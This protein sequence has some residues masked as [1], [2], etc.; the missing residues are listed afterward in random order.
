MVNA[1]VQADRTGDSIKAI[2]Q[3]VREF[4]TTKGVTPAELTREVNGT[5]RELAGRFETS[6]AVLNAMLQN[7]VWHRPDDFYDTVAQKY[8]AMT[9]SQLD[10]AMRGTL[11]PDKLV[12]VVVGDAS[13]VKPQLDAIGLP[14]E[15]VPAAAMAPGAGGGQ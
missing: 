9:V 1:S 6:G 4:L 7:D 13:V 14:V 3:Q 10:A 5:T 12:W 15:V 8:R 2:Q 11:D